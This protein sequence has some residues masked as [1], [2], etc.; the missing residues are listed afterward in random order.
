MRNKLISQAIRLGNLSLM[1]QCFKQANPLGGRPGPQFL[2]LCCAH[3]PP[4]A[5]GCVRGALCRSTPPTCALNPPPQK[6]QLLPVEMTCH[7]HPQTSVLSPSSPDWGPWLP[8]CPA[9]PLASHRRGL[10]LS[11]RRRHDRSHTQRR[12]RA[13]SNHVAMGV[14][15]G[16]WVGGWGG[17]IIS[18]Q[19]NALRLLRQ[20]R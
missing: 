4:T 9:G 14:G 13:S 19:V 18:Y 5:S 10:L 16:G 15:A 17:G 7:P 12:S 1:P 2:F 20:S 11:L 6:L 3:A 8:R